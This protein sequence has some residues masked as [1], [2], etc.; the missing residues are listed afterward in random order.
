MHHGTGE[1]SPTSKARERAYLHAM[2]AHGLEPWPTY[3]RYMSIEDHIGVLLEMH[4]RPTA[5]MCYTDYVGLIALHELM[6]RGLR[7]PDDISILGNEGAAIHDLTYV[8]LTS[9]KAACWEMGA[10]AV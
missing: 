7:V 5:L 3:D 6:R 9:V 1:V 2:R 10:T 4:P 8:K